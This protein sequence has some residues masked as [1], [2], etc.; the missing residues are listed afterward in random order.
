MRMDAHHRIE[1]IV[2]L[3]QR[4]DSVTR[5]EVR[6]NVDDR[7]DTGAVRA[8]DYRFSITIELGEIEV[9]VCLNHCGFF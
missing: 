7:M 5:G 6:A 1:M 9:G 8:L 4:Q 2:P 3:C